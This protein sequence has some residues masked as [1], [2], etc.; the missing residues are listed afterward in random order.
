MVQ[1]NDIN[2]FLDELEK[3]RDHIQ[4]GIVRITNQYRT[5]RLT[6]SIQ[7]LTVVATTRISG[8]LVKLNVYCGDLWGLG[9][10]QPILE[11]AQDL[12]RTLVEKCTALSLEVRSGLLTSHDSVE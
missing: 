8:E 4:R 5:S 3:D 1:F 10:D 11:K 2:E 9:K 7:H 6:A 12:Q